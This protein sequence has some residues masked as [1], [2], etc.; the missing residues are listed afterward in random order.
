M[1]YRDL[2]FKVAPTG[3]KHTGLFPE[4][5]ANWDLIAELVSQKKDARI[6][7]LFAYTGAASMVASAAG[8]LECLGDGVL[9]LFNVERNDAAI[10]LLDGRYH[11]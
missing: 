1:H 9:D 2:T 8:A 3:F 6:L 11:G 5:C 7:N 10:P 4:Q